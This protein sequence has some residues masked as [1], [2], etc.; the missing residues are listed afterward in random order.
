MDTDSAKR[1]REEEE[2]AEKDSESKPK[3]PRVTLESSRAARLAFEMEI[4]RDLL[5][6]IMD[7]YISKFAID[8]ANPAE[9]KWK[10]SSRRCSECPLPSNVVF[11]AAR[12]IRMPIGKPQTFPGMDTWGKA[13]LFF[14]E[15]IE[16]LEQA[17]QLPQ[18][19]D[20]L[21]D[22]IE[23]I[24]NPIAQ[25][26]SIL[27]RCLDGGSPLRPPPVVERYQE[28]LLALSERAR[29]DGV[30]LRELSVF[31]TNDE[32][33]G[34][35]AIRNS[36]K[37]S[38]IDPLPKVPKARVPPPAPRTPAP[39]LPVNGPS[40]SMMQHDT[41]ATTFMTLSQAE[42]HRLL[43]NNAMTLPEAERRRLLGH[44]VYLH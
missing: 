38:S 39:P 18:F 36:Q 35:E 2:D 41:P 9:K 13:V 11:L 8:V 33:D 1:C 32:I 42:R 30:V 26:L 3:K 5:E 24:F 21:C 27:A 14:R 10:E 20:R 31:A 19:A 25:E 37:V 7:A 43:G 44:Q 17:D 34:F 40:A 29:Q 4:Q 16:L 15:S 22:D 6:D 23:A 12:G 28:E